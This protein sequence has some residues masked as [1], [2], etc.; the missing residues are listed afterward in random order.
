MHNI[1][2]KV[3]ILLTDSHLQQK[4]VVLVFSNLGI[5]RSAT[6]VMAYLIAENKWSP[7][8]SFIQQLVLTCLSV[9]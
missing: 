1:I 8:A 2:Q 3:C 4:E 6:I 9:Y 7:Q 5:S